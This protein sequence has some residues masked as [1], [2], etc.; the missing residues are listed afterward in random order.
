MI[1]LAAQV[2]N[3][4]ADNLQKVYEI[5]FRTLL[6]DT[7]N[8]D[9]STT[10]DGIAHQCPLEGCDGVLMARSLLSA[11]GNFDYNDSTLCNNN[12]Y[13]YRFSK[14]KNATNNN[15][16][17]TTN[18][19]VYPNPSRTA[20]NIAIKGNLPE[21]AYAEVYDI[22]GQLKNK[23]FLN[24][25]VTTID[26]SECGYGVLMI[27]VKNANGKEIGEPKKVVLIQQ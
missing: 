10:L 2:D 4:C 14:P 17:N 12:D 26:C 3:V 15:R 8:T 11:Y 25:V 7:L 18:V 21:G 24:Q 9:D 20:F 27:K 19:I 1:D 5:Y 6:I 13:A 22:V 23:V 16:I